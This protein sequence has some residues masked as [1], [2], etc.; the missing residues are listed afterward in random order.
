MDFT[1]PSWINLFRD[2]SDKFSILRAFLETAWD[3][4]LSNL[5]SQSSFV[6][7]KTSESLSF[8]IIVG[9]WH[10]GQFVGML[11]L[12]LLSIQKW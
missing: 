3:N 8:L 5:P 7:I 4:L 9:W 11:K 12:P 2:A 1:Y 6:Q 10:I